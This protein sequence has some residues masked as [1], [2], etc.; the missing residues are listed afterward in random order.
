MSKKCFAYFNADTYA[1]IP[2]LIYKLRLHSLMLLVA[3]ELGL[4]EYVEARHAELE[5]MFSQS[6]VVHGNAR[7]MQRLPRHMRRR[8]ASHN[9][10]RL[11]TNIRNIA[12]REVHTYPIIL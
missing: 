3:V 9:V 10:K 8:A 1:H 11:P 4:A 2:T 5:Q 6:S 12:Q 7:I